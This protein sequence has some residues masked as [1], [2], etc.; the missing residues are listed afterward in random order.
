MKNIN[1]IKEEVYKCSKCGLCKSVCPVYLATKNE[2]YSPRGRNIVLNNF[3]NKKNKLSQKFINDL[4]VCLNCNACKDFCPSN[5]DSTA[6]YAF[7]KEKKAF[8]FYSLSFYLKLFIFYLKNLFHN[9][10]YKRKQ[11][12][13]QNKSKKIVYFENSKNIF[14]NKKDSISAINI[15][16][17]L[18]YNVIVI[19]TEEKIKSFNFDCEFVITSCDDSYSSLILN[20]NLKNKLM[21]IDEFLSSFNLQINVD[22]NLVYHKPLTRKTHCFFPFNVQILNR[23][24]ACSLMENMF[25]LKYTEFSNEILNKLFYTKAEINNKII[26]TSSTLDYIGLNYCIKKLGFNTKVLTYAE[27]IDSKV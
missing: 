19:N 17:K 8:N 21:T 5:I 4:D 15:L 26:I 13:E 20:D 24:G 16:E 27:Y 3:F 7:F 12:K 11:N 1:E 25:L 9:N 14:F 6:I 23:K 2:M 18:G 10:F 22:E